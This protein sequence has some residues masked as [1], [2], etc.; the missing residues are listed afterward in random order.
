MLF[1]SVEGWEGDASGGLVEAG[2][3]FVWAEELDL[4]VVVLVGLHAL[5][6]GEC[7]VEDAGCW[8]EGEVLVWGDLWL[9]PS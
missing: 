5:E 9:Q 4:A 3:V 7:V 6:A 2:H 1:R 8:V